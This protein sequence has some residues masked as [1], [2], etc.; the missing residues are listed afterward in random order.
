M[1]E[2]IVPAP[3]AAA[4]RTSNDLAVKLEMEVA[5]WEVVLI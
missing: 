2:P 3:S 5:T 4:R 1:R